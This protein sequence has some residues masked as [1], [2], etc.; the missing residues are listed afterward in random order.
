MPGPVDG[1]AADVGAPG[2]SPA[3]A[4]TREAGAGRGGGRGT[5]RHSPP[6]EN[7][8]KP[9]LSHDNSESASHKDHASMAT[10]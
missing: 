1:T 3:L 6:V 2:T 8:V 10:R 9:R 5:S 4:A 7:A